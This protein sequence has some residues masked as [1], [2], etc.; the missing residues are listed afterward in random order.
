[1]IMVS[2]FP[3]REA[4]QTAALKQ[5]RLV[6]PQI[7]SRL[8]FAE[9]SDALDTPKWRADPVLKVFRPSKTDQLKTQLDL[10]AGTPLYD[11]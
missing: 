5:V 7:T 9:R 8:H 6:E 11:E 1:M 3:L 10:R 2:R 4:W